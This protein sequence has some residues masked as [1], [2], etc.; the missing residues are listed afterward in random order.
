MALPMP[1]LMVAAP[2]PSADSS[3]IGLSGVPDTLNFTDSL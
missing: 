3:Q 2:L 1:P